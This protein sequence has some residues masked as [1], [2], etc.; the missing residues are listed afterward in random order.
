MLRCS[1]SWW[2][3]FLKASSPLTGLPNYSRKKVKITLIFRRI[4]VSALCTCRHVCERVQPDL[5]APQII[6]Y[7]Y[8]GTIIS[9]HTSSM[10]VMDAGHL[11]SRTSP[12]VKKGITSTTVAQAD[13]SECGSDDEDIIPCRSCD[14]KMGLVLWKSRSCEFTLPRINCICRVQ[15]MLKSQ[16][17]RQTMFRQNHNSILPFSFLHRTQNWPTQCSSSCTKWSENLEDTSTVPSL[18]RQ[19]SRTMVLQAADTVDAVQ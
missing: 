10:L 4:I 16:G 19:S 8:K 11:V 1:R 7:N 5:T 15:G 2:R 13:H 6:A 14:V 18:I 17:A 9:C 3:T 12:S